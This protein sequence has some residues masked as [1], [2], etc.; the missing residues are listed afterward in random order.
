MSEFPLPPA[1]SAF[2]KAHGD[3]IRNAGLLLDRLIGWDEQWKFANKPSQGKKEAYKKVV[4]S[5]VAFGKSK[6]GVA[7]MAGLQQ[8]RVTYLNHLQA[9]GCETWSHE[10]KTDWRLTIGLGTPSVL[11]TGLTTH[12]VYG[13]PYI[14]GSA[15]KGLTAAWAELEGGADKAAI[16]A[17]FG[18]RDA[19]DAESGNIIFFDALP[20]EPPTLKLDVMNPHYGAY[21][22]DKTGRTPPAEWLSP[23]PVY[24]LTVEKTKFLF[25]MAARTSTA[26]ALVATAQQ[27]LLDALE[28]MGAGGKTTAGYGYF[29]TSTP[30]PV[31]AQSIGSTAGAARPGGAATP[32]PAASSPAGPPKDLKWQKGRIGK[33]RRSLMPDGAADP[34][35]ALK[36]YPDRVLGPRGWTYGAKE[37]VEFAV[38]TLPDGKQRVW[39]KKPYFVVVGLP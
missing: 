10:L 2:V 31:P 32:M 33:D 37:A 27:W 36:F 23:V 17:V 29:S 7:L 35:Q 9:T 19:H 34:A 20:V 22:Q 25:S 30:T 13:F 11:E 38:E 16:R 3:Q 5:A 28:N 26:N 6:D 14:P 12:R 21:Y 8:R 1:V 39:V 15:L 18:S 4:A 24:F